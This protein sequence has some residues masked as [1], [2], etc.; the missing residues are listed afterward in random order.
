MLSAAL[1]LHD[2]K[3]GS[4]MTPLSDTYMLEASLSL[5]KKLLREIYSKGYSRIP[6]FEGK[7]ENIIGLLLTRD[8]ILI[9]PDKG[10]IT[11]R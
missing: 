7:R 5:D 3:A 8:L 10:L 2:K 9:N 11:I 4:V 1:E 6:I